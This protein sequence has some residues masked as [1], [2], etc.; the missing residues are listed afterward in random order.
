MIMLARRLLVVLL[1]VVL[2]AGPL[3]VVGVGLAAADEADGFD[4]VPPRL[5]FVDGE[6][7]FWRPGAEDWAPA[8]VNTPL[9]AGDELHTGYRGNLE[10]QLDGQ[11]FV[12]AWGDTHLGLTD[13]RPELLQL[14]VTA[15]HVALDLRR[16]E[17]GASLEVNAPHGA[18]VLDT[19]GYYRVDVG[20]QRTAFTLRRGARATL[21]LADGAPLS[22]GAGEQVI[23]DGA[24]VQ[25]ASAPAAD[26]WD[27]WNEARTMHL[28]APSGAQYVPSGVAGVADLDRYGAWRTEP[29]YGAVWVPSGVPEGWAPY[30]TGRW[31][32]DPHYGWTWVDAAPW[33]WAPYHYGRWIHVRGHWGWAPGPIVARPVY[34]PALVAFFGAPGVS[35]AVATPFVSWVALGWGEPVVPWWRAS[36]FH[37][38]PW[39]G[40][41]GGPRV[42]NNVIVQR[43]TV[44]DAHRI[45]EYRN[46]RI[47]RAMV[48]VR[49]DSFGRRAVHEA[50]LADADL[51]DRRPIHGG[52]PV[53][54][55]RSSFVAADGRGVRPAEGTR[56][57]PV[58]ARRQP[59]RGEPAALPRP[60]AP[61]VDGRRDD[62]PRRDPG[63]G[64][65][66]ERR[67]E[68]Q[69]PAPQPGRG[70]E[71]Q[72]PTRPERQAPPARRPQPERAA[73][74]ERSSPPERS[75]PPVRRPQPE[76]AAPP[77]RSTQPERRVE[78][79]RPVQPEPQLEPV[80]PMQP[81]RRVQPERAR[82]EQVAPPRE[83]P[84][85]DARPGAGREGHGGAAQPPQ[86]RPAAPVSAGTRPAQPATRPPGFD[87]AGAVQRPA[88]PDTRPQT[89]PARDERARG[90]SET[91]RDR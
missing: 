77:E 62:T 53:R 49:E 59:E 35:V 76:R 4:H 27:T 6:V 82:P 83:A 73:Q 2:L 43:T 86:A 29:S 85:R 28:V 63:R 20:P 67:V 45:T 34:A 39:W 31:V 48:G 91:R 87:R 78:P 50:R 80:R 21:A 15:G 8:Q 84:A 61:R 14:K 56:T 89:R 65:R 24:T 23:L 33:G 17:P 57:R 69:R 55:D 11:A 66:D 3:N 79:V 64:E 13:Q 9:A 71:P 38:R 47:R 10:L 1:G 26:V 44:I 30:S 90:S 5:S 36:R 46:A 60:E 16:L 68:P 37:G 52:L 88:A 75:T 58:V 72:Q 19:P 74:P 70:V 81:E 22:V 54:P 41:W 7:S 42:V 32:A 40:G 18:L 12:R 51:R 25:R